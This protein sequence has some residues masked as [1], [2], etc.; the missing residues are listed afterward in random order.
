VGER[1]VRIV[2]AADAPEGVDVVELVPYREG[3]E[4]DRVPRRPDG[5]FMRQFQQNKWV[6]KDLFSVARER[7]AQLAGGGGV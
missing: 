3:G 5:H 1:Y 7:Q 6:T 2:E 4:L